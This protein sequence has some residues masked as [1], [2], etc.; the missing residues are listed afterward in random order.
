M[1]RKKMRKVESKLN[2]DKYL[3]FINKNKN[4]M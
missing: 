2:F 1:K 4:D 3:I